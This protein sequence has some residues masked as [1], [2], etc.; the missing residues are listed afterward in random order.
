MFLG[1]TGLKA[2]RLKVMHTQ[3]NN[4]AVQQSHRLRWPAHTFFFCKG[5]K[6]IHRCRIFG[7]EFGNK[8]NSEEESPH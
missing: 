5:N 3:S 8:K 7:F 1:R 2:K 4:Q 6:F